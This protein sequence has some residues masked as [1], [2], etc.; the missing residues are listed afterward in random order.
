MSSGVSA[1]SSEVGSSA[2]SSV[3]G[4][5]SI[6]PSACPTT[7][8][9]PTFLKTFVT[10]TF[11]LSFGECLLNL[12]NLSVLA[13][14]SDYVFILFGIETYGASSGPTVLIPEE[15][16]TFYRLTTPSIYAVNK[17]N[18]NESDL[19][20]NMSTLIQY[21]EENSNVIQSNIELEPVLATVPANDPLESSY[22]FLEVISLDESGLEIEKT[23]I[24][25]TYSDGTSEEKY[26]TSQDVLPE[27]SKKALL[28][29]WFESLWYVWIPIIAIICIALVL[30]VRRKRAKKQ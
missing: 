15:S 20:T 27:R 10:F 2:A 18:F 9:K 21:F 12:F 24:I 6:G 29:Y 23:K 7:S 28:P 13:E 8:A 26:F 3:T 5:S 1:G 17:A 22:I 14:Y 19:Q 4:A 16:F 25:Y 30:A 11:T